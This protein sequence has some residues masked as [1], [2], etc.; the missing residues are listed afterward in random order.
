MRYQAPKKANP[1]KSN[2]LDIEQSSVIIRLN[3][4]PS[5]QCW[6]FSILRTLTL[7]V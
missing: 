1:S 7:N 4:K 2:A 6:A 5:N 3:K